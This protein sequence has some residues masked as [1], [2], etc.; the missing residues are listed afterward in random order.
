[1]T[2]I[3]S[4]KR[5]A[6]KFCIP[7]GYIPVLTK[8]D[9][10][11]W[12]SWD[13]VRKWVF[14]SPMSTTILYIATSMDGRVARA[15]G[16][17]D[18]LSPYQE[19]GEDFGFAAFEAS[20]DAQIMGRKTYKQVLSMVDE[21]PHARQRTIVRSSNSV[22]LRTPNTECSCESASVLLERL[23]REG[24]KRIWLVGGPSTL[25]DFWVQGLVDQIELFVVPLVLGEGPRLFQDGFPSNWSL[26][27]AQ[28]YPSGMLHCR[29]AKVPSFPASGATL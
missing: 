13:P 6:E 14:S 2:E 16:S 24:F 10:L 17:L 25:S 11:N 23:G 7:L 19:S 20:I 5:V 27:S 15:D 22:D 8:N 4:S 29:Y 12:R 26:V 9:T 28:G 1:M 18:W 3:V 21:W